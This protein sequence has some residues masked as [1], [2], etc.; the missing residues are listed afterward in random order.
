MGTSYNWE[1]KNRKCDTEVSKWRELRRQREKM[2]NYSNPRE[3]YDKSLNSLSNDYAI[4][5]EQIE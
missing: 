5:V 3:Y 4:L 1:S 2:E